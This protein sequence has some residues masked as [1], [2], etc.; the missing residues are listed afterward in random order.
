MVSQNCEKCIITLDLD[1]FFFFVF[2]SFCPFGPHLWHIEV[3][4]LGGL[5]RVVATGQRHQSH[6]SAR[7]E[8]HL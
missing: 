2:L 5:I 7:S 6:S 8:L 1:F 3:P 4:R